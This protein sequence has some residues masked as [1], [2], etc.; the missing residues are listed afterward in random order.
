VAALAQTSPAVV[1]LRDQQRPAQRLAGEART[2]AQ[3]DGALNY[4]PNAHARSLAATETRH[5]A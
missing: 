3:R 2:G 1:S 5:S 4:Y